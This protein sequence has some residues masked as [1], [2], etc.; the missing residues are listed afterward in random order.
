MHESDYRL[1]PGYNEAPMQERA[2]ANDAR[3]GGGMPKPMP[4]SETRASNLVDRI[5]EC[6]RRIEQIQAALNKMYEEFVSVSN[7]LQ[8]QIQ[9]LNQF[10]GKR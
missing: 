9:E 8:G 6:E 1:A 7:N 10:I 2:R 5:N 4:I 3:I